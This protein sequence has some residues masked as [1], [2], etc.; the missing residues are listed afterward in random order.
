MIGRGSRIKENQGS[1]RTLW[2]KSCIRDILPGVLRSSSYDNIHHKHPREA[3]LYSLDSA[4]TSESRQW[5]V[6]L[7]HHAQGGQPVVSV[8]PSTKR[9][10]DGAHA[11]GG[12]TVVQYQIHRSSD[13]QG[14]Y[15]NTVS[16]AMLTDGLHTGD[17]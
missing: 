4:F 12:I 5:R 15:Q 8:L 17:R 14:A 3:L 1:S 9:R 10:I 6:W 11:V 7:G 13:R 2:F 16:L